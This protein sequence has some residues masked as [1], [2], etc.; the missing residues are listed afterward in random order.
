MYFNPFP[1]P[2]A[3]YTNLYTVVSTL[4]GARAHANEPATHTHTYTAQI[5]GRD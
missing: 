1:H 4:A 2:R 3:P 5:H